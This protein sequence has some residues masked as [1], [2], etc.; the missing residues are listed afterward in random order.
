LC[1]S[2][3]DL[4]TVDQKQ[5]RHNVLVSSLLK[6]FQDNDEGSI[7]LT[8]HTI[9]SE[10][11]TK[12][13]DVWLL[14]QLRVKDSRQKDLLEYIAGITAQLTPSRDQ[15]NRFIVVVKLP[16]D[17]IPFYPIGPKRDPADRDILEKVDIPVTGILA[18]DK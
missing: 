15:T 18:H 13:T 1:N 4:E 10:D 8:G 5:D 2:P 9:E 7:T 16:D 3:T 6:K 17:C 12:V 11:G 14:L